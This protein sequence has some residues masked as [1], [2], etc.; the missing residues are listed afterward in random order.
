MFKYTQFFG[1]KRKKHVVKNWV[2]RGPNCPV[3]EDATRA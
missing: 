1:K 3:R 2:G